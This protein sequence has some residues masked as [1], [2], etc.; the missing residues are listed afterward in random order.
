MKEG[1]RLRVSILRRV[2]TFTG[3]VCFESAQRNTVTDF[4]LSD[5]EHELDSLPPETQILPYFGQDP[6]NGNPYS[7]AAYQFLEILG[8]GGFSKVYLVRKFDTGKIYAMKIISKK[9]ASK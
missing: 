8:K 7:P 9:F 3:F 5:S 4:V 2:L 6:T 1:F